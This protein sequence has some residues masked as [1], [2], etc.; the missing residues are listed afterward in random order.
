LKNVPTTTASAKSK[1]IVPNANFATFIK[2][3]GNKYSSTSPIMASG[4]SYTNLV[5]TFWQNYQAKG[6]KNLGADLKKLDSELDAQVKQA[7]GG[8]GG[9][10]P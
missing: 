8:S 2:I 5:Q 9:G 4:A 10:V 1:E 6:S 3:F 7:G